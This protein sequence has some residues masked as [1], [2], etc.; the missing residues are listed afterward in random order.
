MNHFLKTIRNNFR[1][2]QPTVAEYSNDI[3][4]QEIFPDKRLQ[5][6]IYCYWEL[7]TTQELSNPFEYRVVADGCIDIFFEVENPGQN[8]VMGFSKKCTEFSLG[9]S[10]HFRGIRFLPAIFPQLFNISAEELSNRVEELSAVVPETSAFISKNLS[11]N[12]PGETIKLLF[13]TYFTDLLA[14]LDLEF[15]SRFYQALD[16]IIKD[17]ASVKITK[18]LHT[19]ISRRQLQRLFKFYIGDS[20]KTFSQVVRFQQILSA[21]RSLERLKKEKI[22]FDAGYY[23]QAHFIKEFK[24]FY[25]TTPGCVIGFE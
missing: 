8:F 20:P 22:F 23:D 6:F 9:R 7:K 24:T 13:D 1:P 2:Q 3:K 10:F 25:G 16:I 4:Y 17:P 5:N 18:D 21:K 19:G 15:D 14:R 12:Q 11:A